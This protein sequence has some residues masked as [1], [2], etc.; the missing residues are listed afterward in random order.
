MG[1]RI[2]DTI[3]VI[4]NQN[5]GQLVIALDCKRYAIGKGLAQKVIVERVPE[6]DLEE[7][8][9]LSR[10]QEGQAGIIVH[11]GGNGPIRRRILEMGITKGSQIF[12]EK[13]A[14]LK[15]PLELVIR[16]YHISL[17]VDEADLIMV[18]KDSCSGQGI[19]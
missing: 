6:T 4:A 7:P 3:E 12:V 2:G 15:D 13:Y 14:P 8:I 18:R 19:Q 1:L 11:V 5:K 17:R 10:L 9:R 16:G